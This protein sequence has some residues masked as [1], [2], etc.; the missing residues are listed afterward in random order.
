M[1]NVIVKPKRSLDRVINDM[2]NDFVS[3]PRFESQTAFSPRVD[4]VEGDENVVL[5][6]EVPGIEKSDIKV[7]VRDNSLT[8]S[9]ERNFEIDREKEQY[10]H[11]EMVSGSF[12]RT[13]S[14]P[15]TVDQEKIKADHKNGLLIV[16]L[17]KKE[18]AK[19]KE[20]EVSIA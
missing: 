5:T 9:G 17:A 10:V 7:L 1:N 12:S 20:I 19:P 4:I 3:F 8:V 2:F 6:F 15:E 13:F 11:R 18:A 16:T 14:L